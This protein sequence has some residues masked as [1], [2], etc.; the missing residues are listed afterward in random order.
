MGRSEGHEHLNYK[1]LTCAEVSDRDVVC[2]I[3][4]QH[5]PMKQ[6]IYV[7]KNWCQCSCCLQG[8]EDT[9]CMDLLSYIFPCFS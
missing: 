2:Q 5:E 1:S 9:S 8:W 3:C 4:F 7:M 6:K